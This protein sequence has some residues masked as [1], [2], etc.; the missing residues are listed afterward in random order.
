MIRG[1]LN[2]PWFLWAAL[3]L[4]GA[5]VWAFVWPRKAVTATTG[6]RYFVIRCGHALTWLFLAI[7]FF[8]RGIGPDL[9]GGSSFFALA[10]GLVYLLFMIMTFIMK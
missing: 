8:L 4:I 7:S 10:G 3:A 2:L 9:N 1:W 5:V 6:F